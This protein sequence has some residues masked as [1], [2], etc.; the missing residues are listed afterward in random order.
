M[1]APSKAMLTIHGKG[2]KACCHTQDE[3]GQGKLICHSKPMSWT[4]HS[5]I[6]LILEMLGARHGIRMAQ[7]TLCQ[8]ILGMSETNLPDCAPSTHALQHERSAQ[9]HPS[10]NIWQEGGATFSQHT[11]TACMPSLQWV[12]C[13]FVCLL[14]F[15][16]TSLHESCAGKIAGVTTHSN[17]HK[18]ACLSA[19]S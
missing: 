6:V 1:K 19:M 15:F 17:H 11:H 16:S 4:Q 12:R 5:H 8:L 13:V 3:L 7:A 9:H 2:T 10:P 18:H 14:A